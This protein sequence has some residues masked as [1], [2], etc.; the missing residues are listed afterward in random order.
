MQDNRHAIF[1]VGYLDPDT[2]GYKLLHAKTGDALQFELH[3]PAQRV[4][5]ENRQSFNFSAHA[6]REDLC[7]LVERLAPKNVVF[8]HGDPEAIEWMSDH[9]NGSCRK[10]APTI[11]ETV[12]LEP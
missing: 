12:V 2:L 10:F 3:G 7:R 4:E 5:V 1:F 9:V 11:G 8:V 6:R